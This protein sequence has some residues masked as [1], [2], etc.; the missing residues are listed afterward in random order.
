MGQAAKQIWKS[1]EN[2]YALA[3]PALSKDVGHRVAQAL[4]RFHHAPVPLM[5]FRNVGQLRHSER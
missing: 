5:G 3:V 1:K 4:H 2:E